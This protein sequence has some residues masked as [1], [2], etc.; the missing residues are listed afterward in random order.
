ME[1][2][3]IRGITVHSS[4]GITEPTS[5][6]TKK[7]VF[8]LILQTNG[9]LTTDWAGNRPVSMGDLENI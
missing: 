4:Q 8:E 1:T 2:R 7:Q 6:L 3:Y 9:I 5:I